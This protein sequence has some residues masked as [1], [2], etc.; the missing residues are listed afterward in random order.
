MWGVACTQSARAGTVPHVGPYDQLARYGF[1]G[2]M[3]SD[4]TVAPLPSADGASEAGAPDSPNPRTQ[5]PGNKISADTSY[6]TRPAAFGPGKVDD[7]GLWGHLL[8]IRLFYGEQDADGVVPNYGCPSAS[9]AAASSASTSAW[10]GLWG[11]NAARRPPPDWIA[12]VERGECAF[13][14][15]VRL[16]QEL[17]A[18]AVVVGDAK[19]AYDEDSQIERL[20]SLR[21]IPWDNDEWDTGETRPITMYPDGDADDIVIPSCFVIRSSYLELLELVHELLTASS[22]G[23]FRRH[24][25]GLE[26]GLF[27]D[28][29]LPD[30]SAIDLGML[31][32]FMPSILT[33]VFVIVQHLKQVVK[34]WRER[35]SVQAVRHLPCY[36]WHAEGPWELLAASSLPAAPP[37]GAGWWAH[38]S[39]Y[40]SCAYDRVRHAVVRCVARGALPRASEPRAEAEAAVALEAQAE[41]APLVPDEPAPPAISAA[42][43][44][45]RYA[46]DVCPICLAGFE[47]GDHV[48]VLPCGHVYH[49]DEVDDWLTG[50][51]RLCPTCKRDILGA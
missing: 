16:A 38:A 33:I 7:D 3:V 2:S 42:L 37:K 4:D 9:H 1:V 39:Y 10:A 41:R 45:R 22:G 18:I 17:G 40:V 34:Q 47:E 25:D 44:V 14:D 26:V 32:L 36:R 29:S 35:A 46:Q 23:L 15:K 50:T 49:R 24:T 21:D 19:H 6:L 11:A 5:W 28:S 12:L 13:S 20:V 31:L 27:L 51:R 43:D 48:R 30:L 8:P